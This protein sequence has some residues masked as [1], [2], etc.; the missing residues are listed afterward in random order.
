[1]ITPAAAI[2]DPNLLGDFFLG[3]SWD[4]WRAVLKGAHAEQLS[5]SERAFFRKVAGRDPPAHRVRELWIKAGR[6]AGKDS[7][8]SAI[9]TVAALV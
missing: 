1:M 2:D 9:A 5:E 4:P 8:A 3:K 6:R 7:I